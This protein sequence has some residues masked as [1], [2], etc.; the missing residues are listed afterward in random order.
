MLTGDGCS[1]SVLR[2]PR[3]CI[4]PGSGRLVGTIPP[5]QD[6]TRGPGIPMVPSPA[7]SRPT[8][9]PRHPGVRAL[10]PVPPGM[11]VAAAVPVEKNPDGVALHPCLDLALV[12]EKGKACDSAP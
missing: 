3:A 1:D 10:R 6:Q 9:L 2:K 4:S 7:P 5:T 8:D 11:I 12:T